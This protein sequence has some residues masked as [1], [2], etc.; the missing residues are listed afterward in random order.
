MWEYP[1]ARA[2]RGET[3]TPGIDFIH[4]ADNGRENWIRVSA[5]PFRDDAGEIRGGVAILQNVDDEKRAEQRLRE[6]EARLQ[7]AVDLLKLGRYAW[8]PQTNEL[9]W[10]DTLRAMWGVPVDAPVNYDV[11][12]AGVQPDDLARV[13][14]AIQRCADPQGDGL[15]DVEYRVIGRT[16]G[17]ERWIATRGTGPA[18]QEEGTY[19]GRR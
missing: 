6:S 4:T 11:W 16:D 17:V 3:V 12:R 13:E 2:L 1:G 8:N 14:A 15:Y 10:D 19:P 9:Q 5:A 7:A 18:H